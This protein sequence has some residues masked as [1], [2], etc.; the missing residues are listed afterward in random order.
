MKYRINYVGVIVI[1]YQK[2]SRIKVEINTK[3]SEV[4][5]ILRQSNTALNLQLFTDEIKEIKSSLIQKKIIASLTRNSRIL[6][7]LP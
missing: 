7:N 4:R 6:L 2:L 5:N 1:S 3:R